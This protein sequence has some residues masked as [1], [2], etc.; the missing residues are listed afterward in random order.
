MVYE[1]VNTDLEDK[2]GTFMEVKSVDDSYTQAQMQELVESIF[3]EK[4]S[5]SK[6]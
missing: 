2:I 4:V 3:D 1:K 5:R 6:A